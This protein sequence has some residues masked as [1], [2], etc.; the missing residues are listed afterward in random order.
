MK[1]K[2]VSKIYYGHRSHTRLV[3]CKKWARKKKF[4]LTDQQQFINLPL[5][6][7]AIQLNDDY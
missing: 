4:N 7:R 5:S 1:G 6:L 3:V 2:N